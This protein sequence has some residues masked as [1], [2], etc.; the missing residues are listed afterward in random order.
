MQPVI[1]D[2][3]YVTFKKKIEEKVLDII[4]QSLEEGTLDVDG[5]RK[6]ARYITDAWESIQS[7]DELKAFIQKLVAQWP[8]FDPVLKDAEFQLTTNVE[9][10]KIKALQNKL[11]ALSAPVISVN[12]NR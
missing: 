6:S 5:A 3:N 2:Q 4:T 7:T 9:Q 8:I 10:D 12:Q 1:E 11:S